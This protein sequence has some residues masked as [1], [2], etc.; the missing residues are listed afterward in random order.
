MEAPCLK[1]LRPAGIC[2]ARATCA[3]GTVVSLIDF[4]SASKARC[5]RDKPLPTLQVEYESIA[6]STDLG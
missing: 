3:F 1:G 5:N 4:V 2:L 6:S